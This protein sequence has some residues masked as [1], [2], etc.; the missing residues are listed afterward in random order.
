MKRPTQTDVAHLAG[1]SRATVSYAIS[2]RAAGA[3]ALPEETRQRVIQAAEQLGYQPH[4]PAQSLRAG[5]T[6]T[7]GMLIPDMRNPHFWQIVSGFEDEARTQG[8]D[9]LLSNASLNPDRELESVHTLLRGRVDGLVLSL[10]FPKRLTDEAGLLARRGS[11]VVMIGGSFTGLDMVRSDYTAGALKMMSHL[12]ALG[13]RHI[14][15]V[16]GVATPELG[17]DRLTAYR[18]A[19]LDAGLP[20]NEDLIEHCG[21]NQA[22]G[23]QAAARLLDRSPRPTAILAVNDLLAISVLRLLADRGLRV[24]QDVS[25][26]GFDDIDVASFL[27]PSLTTVRINAEEV[28]R[29]AARLIFERM[30]DPERPHQCICIPAELI[31]RGSTGPAPLN[32]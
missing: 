6:K 11:P 14:G 7:L 15:L 10:S 26:A 16:F 27:C 4:A 9:L 29:T 23:Y 13:H 3:I 8:Y 30:A 31:Q 2:G 19:I 12:L 17:L 28:G 5:A 20:L 1:V 18:K 32:R 22:D 21:P 24:P 25:V